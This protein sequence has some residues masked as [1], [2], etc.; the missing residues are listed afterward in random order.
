MRPCICDFCGDYIEDGES[1]EVETCHATT[2][3]GSSWEIC[4][5]CHYGMQ[6]QSKG[7][8]IDLLQPD[9]VNK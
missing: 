7:I 2:G 9:E 5:N 4:E 1:I 3:K 8:K 6:S